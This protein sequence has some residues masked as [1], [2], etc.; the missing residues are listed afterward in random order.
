[1]MPIIIDATLS[2]PPSSVTCFRDVTLYANCFIKKNVVIECD[3]NM[4]DIYWHWLK[5]YGAFDFVA[6]I[7]DPFTERDISIRPTRASIT[8]PRIDASALHIILGRLEQLRAG[9][10]RADLG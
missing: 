10:P 4:R 5:R 2:E 6:D 7:V 3:R 9:P 1:M 8:V